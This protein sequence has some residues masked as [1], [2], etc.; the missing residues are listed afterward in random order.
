[1]EQFAGEYFFELKVAFCDNCRMVQLAELV[2]RERMF[3]ANY[4]FFSSTSNRMAQH[5]R[6]FASW[7]REMFLSDEDPFVL[8]LGSNDGIMLKNF[9]DADVRHLGIEPSANV[10]EAARQKGVRTISQFFDEELAAQVLA[11]DGPADAVLGANVMCHIP[12]IHSVFAGVKKLLKPRGVLVF[13]DPYLGDIVEKTSYDQ[14]YDEHAF[15]FSAESISFLA[16]LHEL[17]LIDV[18]PQNVHGGS[19]RYVLGH[20][21]AYPISPAVDRLREKET[22]LG[23]ARPETYAQLR[24][25]IEASRDQL[26]AM[27]EE[28]S[29]AGHRVAGYAATSKSTTV[30]NYCGLNPRLVEFISDT[31]P[32]KQG[33]FSPGAHIP[34]RPY[35][36]F[37][38][39][40]P[41]YGLLFGWNHAEEIMAKEEAFTAAGGKWIVYVPRVQVLA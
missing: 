25:N 11:T 10:A 17:E 7:V 35:D 31:T 28:F 4:A 15:Y 19:M 29:R 8:E 27:L 9:A 26:R 20:R 36:E 40:Y 33:K 1:A 32:I 23:L 37:K 41:D 13:E 30:T 21:G 3:H 12:Y 18:L 2:E 16:S 6:E 34:V 38:A 39:N 14:I 24:R 5:F 22:A